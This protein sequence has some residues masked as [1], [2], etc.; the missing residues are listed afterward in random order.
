MVRA[1][2]ESQGSRGFYS[3]LNVGQVIEILHISIFPICKKQ[4]LPPCNI[5]DPP[6]IAQ[7]QPF[8]PIPNPHKHLSKQTSSD[9][10][11][12][13]SVLPHFHALPKTGSLSLLDSH[14]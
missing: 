11:L 14:A 3:Q 12:A 5:P 6:G 1:G 8:L 2:G 4:A 9:L 13:T 10:L 7:S